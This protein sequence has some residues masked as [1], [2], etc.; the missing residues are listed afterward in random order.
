MAGHEARQTES[1]ATRESGSARTREKL[2]TEVEHRLMIR[3]AKGSESGA[4]YPEAFEVVSIE[5]RP[6]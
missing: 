6:L 2:T 5:L 3:L 1:P 4:G